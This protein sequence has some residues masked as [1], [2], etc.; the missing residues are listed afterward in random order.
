MSVK[1]AVLPFSR[2]PEVDTTLGPEMRSTGEVM[3][4]DATFGRAFIK[5]Q[6]AAGTNLPDS[7]RVFVSLNDRDKSAAVEIGRALA[8]V[9]CAIVATQVRLRHSRPAAFPSNAWWAKFRNAT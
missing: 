8:D 1:E 9:G 4:I 5:S 2:F 6:L 3:G 7:G